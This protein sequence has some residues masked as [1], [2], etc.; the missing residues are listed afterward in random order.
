MERQRHSQLPALQ[1]LPLLHRLSSVK[2]VSDAEDRDDRRQSGAVGQDQGSVEV[3]KWIWLMFTSEMSFMFFVPIS[4]GSL[5]SASFHCFG[6]LLT[7]FPWWQF[8]DGVSTITI[9]VNILMLGHAMHA[10]SHSD[11]VNDYTRSDGVYS[12]WL[13]RVS[14]QKVGTGKQAIGDA[15]KNVCRNCKRLLMNSLHV[16]SQ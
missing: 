4:R 5:P 6:A 1:S 10:S 14:Q 7:S 15:H 13:Y 2:S 8:Y 12:F 3:C 16:D 11:M 9:L